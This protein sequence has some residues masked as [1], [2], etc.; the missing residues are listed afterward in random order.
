MNAVA[1]ARV[2][3]APAAAGGY[4]IHLGS[5]ILGGLG[6]AWAEPARGRAVL[7]VYD[8]ALPDL[9]SQ[10]EASLSEA[11]LRVVPAPVPSGEGSKSLTEVERL[12]RLAASSGMRRTDSLVAVGGGMI[13]DLAGFVAASYQRGIDLVHV[14]TTLLAMVDSSIGGKTGVN[15]PE[16]KNYVGAIWQPRLVYM[17]VEALDSLPRRELASGFAE[18]IKYAFLEGGELLDLVESWPRLP[19][20]TDALID[21]VGRCVAHKL[22]VVAVDERE[23]GLRASLNL[24]HTAGHGIEAATDYGRYAH[25]EAISLGLLVALQLSAEHAELD[26]EHRERA[27]RV[28]RRHG[29]PEELHPDVDLE[30]VMEALGR[31]KKS[32]GESLNMILLSAPGEVILGADPPRD[33]VRRAI[34]ELQP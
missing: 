4:P 21:L 34:Q 5:G 10:A 25:G 33:D 14:P 19:G 9:A 29:L 11:G 8:A 28:I 13:G 15:L 26:A 22:R 24:G 12:T 31:D 23:S 20:P 6:A 2:L 32:D 7:L 1:A 27:A 17:D 18:V 30:L 3:D 16:G